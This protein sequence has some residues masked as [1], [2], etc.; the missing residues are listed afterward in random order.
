MC[1]G[2]GPQGWCAGGSRGPVEANRALARLYGLI[3]EATG[4]T[5][6]QIDALTFDEADELMENCPSLVLMLEASRRSVPQEARPATGAR[7]GSAENP[8]ET[9]EQ[10]FAQLVAALKAD[11]AANG[12]GRPR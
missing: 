1:G 2:C 7:R 5:Y 11:A 12:S 9:T 6:T 3:V 4:W 8:I 10:G